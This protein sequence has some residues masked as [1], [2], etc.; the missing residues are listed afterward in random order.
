MTDNKGLKYLLDQPNLNARQARWLAF[1]SEYDFEIQHI[2]GK[3]NKVTDPLSRNAKLN[4]TTAIGTSV[5]DL[6]EQLKEGIKEDEI[7]QKLQTTAKEEPTENLIKGYSLNENGFLLYKDKLYVPKVKL[8]ILDEVYKTPYSGHPG[9]QK[10]ITM[11]RKEYFWPNM[12]SEV[13]KYIARC[14][15]CQQVK[16]EHQHP[17]G[18]LQPL[19]L[20]GNGRS[21]VWILL[22][23]CLEIGIKMT[24]LW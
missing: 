6:N 9:Y 20:V 17:A 3:E 19:F 1:L 24:L 16:T 14:L 2:K 7:Y 23:D 8:L 5:S 11:L 12:K 4:F 18:L 13:A 15:D 21:S 22:L 10:T